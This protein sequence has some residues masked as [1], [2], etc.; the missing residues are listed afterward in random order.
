MS[1]MSSPSSSSDA[2]TNVLEESVEEESV[3]E[4]SV[5]ESVE[6]EIEIPTYKRRPRPIRPFMYQLI[7]EQC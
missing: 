2:S 3:G 5:E 7:C 4:E 1:D 6:E